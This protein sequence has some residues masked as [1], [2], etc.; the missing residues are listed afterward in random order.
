MIN[1]HKLTKEQALFAMKNGEF[2]SDII[3]SNDKVVI[4]LTQ[5]WCPQWIHMNS[6]IYSLDLEYD[7]DIYELIY[8]KVDYFNEFIY[9]KENI[10]QN[11]DIPYLRYYKNGK[12]F[13]ESNYKNQKNFKDILNS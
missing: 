12:L 8:N 10:W 3:S 5:S 7:L 4:I 9:H 2:S 6:W 1:K 11:H 13:K